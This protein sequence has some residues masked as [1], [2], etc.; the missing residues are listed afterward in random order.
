[1]IPRI[2]GTAVTVLLGLLPVAV[3][4][5]S[6]ARYEPAPV[7]RACQ[8]LGQLLLRPLVDSAALGGNETELAELTLPPGWDAVG[9]GHLHGRPEI[10]YVLSGR[11]GHI[12]NDTVFEIGP[13]G[14]GIVRP[15]DRVRHKVLSAEP[16]RL[17]AIW[18]P[19]GEL[20]QILE[21]ARPAICAG[22]S[23]QK[24]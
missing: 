13:G 1:M 17:L 20:A 4:A 16:V 6:R 18:A 21:H 7:A 8:A 24:R 2:A 9:E 5:Q 12:V 11:L 19:G 23:D 3:T 15:G 14:V 10:L 22:P